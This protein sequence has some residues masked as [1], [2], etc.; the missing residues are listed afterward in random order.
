MA[1]MSILLVVVSKF[2][3]LFFVLPL[4]R[5]KFSKIQTLSRFVVLPICFLGMLTT[6]KLLFLVITKYAW[7]RIDFRGKILAN[8]DSV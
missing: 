2:L 3:L 1:T 4:I 6:S 8:S 5:Y 7:E